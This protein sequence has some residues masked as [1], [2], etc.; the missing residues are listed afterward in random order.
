MS[1]KATKP[2]DIDQELANAAEAIA[3]AARWQ[4]TATFH[5]DRA[6][7]LARVPQSGEYVPVA[8]SQPHEQAKAEM[9]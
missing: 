7:I 3:N 5:L 1:V 4:I 2:T 8:C 6:R 9:P